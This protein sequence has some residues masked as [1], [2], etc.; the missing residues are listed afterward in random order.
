MFHA[1]EATF[2]LFV[3]ELFRGCYIIVSLKMQKRKYR[4]AILF[5]FRQLV[6]SMLFFVEKCG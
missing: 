2:K 1:L 4:N 5:V 6:V 3:D